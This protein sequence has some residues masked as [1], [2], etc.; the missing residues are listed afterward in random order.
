VPRQL[1]ERP[2]LLNLLTDELRKALK[3]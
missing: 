1:L 2:G 3:P